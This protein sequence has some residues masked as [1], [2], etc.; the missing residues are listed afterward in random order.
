MHKLKQNIDQVNEVRTVMSCSVLTVT[1]CFHEFPIYNTKS[2]KL[3][4]FS[5]CIKIVLYF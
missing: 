4:Q 3:V 1:I 2:F 5:F